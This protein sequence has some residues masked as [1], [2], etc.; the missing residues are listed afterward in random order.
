MSIGQLKEKLHL[1]ATLPPRPGC[2]SRP[3]YQQRIFFRC[4]AN[5]AGLRRAER[6]ARLV[7]AQIINREFDW[8][9]YDTWKETPPG[10]CGDWV[11]KFEIWYIK[12]K[13]GRAETWKGDYEKGLKGLSRSVKLSPAALQKAILTTEPNTKSRRRACMAV[14]ALAKFAGVK[15]DVTPFRGSY[16]SAKAGIRN[17]PSCA[18]IAEYRNRLTNPAWRWVYGM[19]AVYGLR[20]HEVF[21]LDLS[22]FPIVHVLEETKTGSREVW[23]CYPEWADEWGLAAQ[24]L[25]PIQLDR[26][27]QQIG[28]SVTRYL[29]PL[30]PFVPY[31]LRHAWAVRTV[32]FG[33]PDAL[34]AQQMGHSLDVHNRTY[35]RWI[36]KRDHQQMYDI[37]LRRE[38]RP[39]PPP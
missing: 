1:R 25:P 2:Q 5:P 34:S 32:S 12:V 39:R 10:S 24:Q 18:A 38:D 31:D 37:L 33:W 26:T 8:G 22:E 13:G 3:P 21:K 20:N 11:R 4:P 19:M 30:L 36:N 29:S 16:S 15:F 27:N 7:G 9:R 17:V 14:G 6:E 23:P 28:N 35:Q